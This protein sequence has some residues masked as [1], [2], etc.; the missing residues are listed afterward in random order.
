MRVIVTEESVQVR[1]APWEKLV[2][3]MRNIT[4]ARADVSDVEVVPNAVREAMR[5]GIKVGLRVPWLLYIARSMRL[6]Q[7]FIVRR[8]VP[9]LSLEV[10]NHRVLRRVLVSTPRADELA[11]QLRPG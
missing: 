8:R 3:L 5:G 7:V 1:L 9:G 10:S 11:R 6:D 4:L 2:G